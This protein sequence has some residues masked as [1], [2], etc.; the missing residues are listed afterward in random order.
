MIC[1]SNINWYHY[2]FTSN[3]LEF[4]MFF[5]KNKLTMVTESKALAD[6][7]APVSIDPLHY[8]SGVSIVPPFAE[9]YQVCYF[10]MGCFWGA[11]RLF[12]PLPGV[13]STAVGYQG[14][15]T[16]NARYQQVCTGQTGHSEVVLVVFDPKVISYAALLMQF[17]EHHEPTQGM[18][19]GPDQGS[20]YRSAIYCDSEH[21][22]SQARGSAE[23]YQQALQDAGNPQAIT[24]EITLAKPFYYAEQEHQQYLAKH[25]QGYC[26]LAGSGVCYPGDE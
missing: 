25:P 3:H 20:Q 4:V 23:R 13:F 18:R 7:P 9:K 1:L 6:N 14:G 21:Q 8:V 5:E 24:T 26:S 2:S 10:A 12:W 22:L 11:E 16:A 17:W 15:Y 19:Q